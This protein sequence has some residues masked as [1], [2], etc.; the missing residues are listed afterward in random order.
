MEI[1]VLL[2][3]G[4]LLGIPIVAIIALVRSAN[5]RKLLDE[6]TSEYRDKISDLTGEIAKLRREL[7]EVSQRVGQ[8]AQFLRPRQQPRHRRSRPP[9]HQLQ[10]PRKHSVQSSTPSRQPSSMSLHSVPRLLRSR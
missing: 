3:G 2:V 5:T 10:R 7:A 6:T 4:F 8:P 1:I 9:Q